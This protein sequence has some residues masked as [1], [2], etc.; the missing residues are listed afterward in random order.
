MDWAGYWNWPLCRATP[1]SS[2]R[3]ADFEPAASAKRRKHHGR[4]SMTNDSEPSPAKGISIIARKLTECQSR[5][6]LNLPYL[7]R[8]DPS[9]VVLIA[10]PTLERVMKNAIAAAALA[11]GL[12][13]GS[14]TASFGGNVNGGAPPRSGVPTVAEQGANTARGISRAGTPHSPKKNLK[15]D[16]TSKD[17]M[18]R[19]NK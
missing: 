19:N 9:Y 4:W 7:E 8:C 14:A 16:H 17:R 1:R 13:F 11:L 3:E 5:D 6:S 10:K 2:L 12:A 15:S 18:K